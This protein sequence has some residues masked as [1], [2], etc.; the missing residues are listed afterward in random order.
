MKHSESKGYRLFYGTYPYKITLSSYR[1]GLVKQ[2]HDFKK[3]NTQYEM[4]VRQE[5][6]SISLFFKE[7]ELMD[8]LKKE[9]S[10]KIV[11]I[12]EP[13]EKTLEVLKSDSRI[14]VKN[15]L[16]HGCRYRVMLS[17]SKMNASTKDYTAFVNLIE[18]NSSKYVVPRH[19]KG[20]IKG[21]Y[22]YFYGTPYFYVKDFFGLCI[23]GLMFSFFVVYAPNYL[24]HPDNYIEANPM[25]TPA[26]IVPEWYFLPFYAVLR[27]IPDK[28]GGVVLMVFA[29]VIL[30]FLPNLE[31]YNILKHPIL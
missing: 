2:F 6:Y 7:K 17:S 8:K 31:Q 15:K 24:G 1:D 25:V 13:D 21:D 5:G 19:L 14:E 11:D 27:T 22:K 10:K 16:T 29:I 28:L 30:L 4:K 12:T 23:F 26:H 20:F 18:R 3:K 9:F